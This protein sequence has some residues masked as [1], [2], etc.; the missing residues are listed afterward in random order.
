MV[1][2]LVFC[3]AQ[4]ML[5]QAHVVLLMER[6]QSGPS[7]NN[8]LQHTR[9]AQS[10]S[11]RKGTQTKQ[12]LKNYGLSV[13]FRSHAAHSTQHRKHP[14]L[15]APPADAT[16]CIWTAVELQEC[17]RV[18]LCDFSAMVYCPQALLLLLERSHEH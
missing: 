15:T 7:R 2:S 3:A 1:P 13:S 9:P 14:T 8:I 18:C 16:V 5:T 12:Y 4:V 10:S 11:R 17:A 6:F